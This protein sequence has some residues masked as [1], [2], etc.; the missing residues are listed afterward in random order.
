MFIETVEA[1]K[2]GLS[3]YDLVN[4]SRPSVQRIIQRLRSGDVKIV[5]FGSGGTGKSTFGKMIS[6]EADPNI[7]ATY[8][9][10]RTTEE[11]KFTRDKLGIITIPPGQGRRDDE[12]LAAFRQVTDGKFRIIINMVA[13]G[14][15]SF[16]ELSYTESKYYTRG[17]TVEEFL[18]IYTEKCRQEEINYLKQIAMPITMSKAVPTLMMTLVSKQDLWWHDRETIKKHYCDLEYRSI[19]DGI[20]STKGTAG[21]SHEYVSASLLINGFTSGIGEPLKSISTDYSQP[22]QFNNLADVFQKIDQFCQ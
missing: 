20:L 6:G 7:L 13:Y 16:G 22:L 15:H 11:F 5:V 19:I 3:I 8:R 4:K 17:M 14:Y 10:S 2:T 9:E 18:E 12:W 1:L 21:F